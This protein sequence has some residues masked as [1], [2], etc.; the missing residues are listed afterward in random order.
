[1]SADESNTLLHVAEEKSQDD[2]EPKN[3]QI[4]QPASVKRRPSIEIGHWGRPPTVDSGAA[5]ISDEPQW[6][7]ANDHEQQSSYRNRKS[8]DFQGSSASIHAT[9][10]NEHSSESEPP[11]DNH[12]RIPHGSGGSPGAFAESATQHNNGWKDRSNVRRTSV[13]H[14][15][16]VKVEDRTTTG[17]FVKHVSLGLVH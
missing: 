6:Q 15:K 1:M 8:K 13:D 5:D 10:A 11:T 17:G 2:G 12:S 9:N 14:S 7:S 4:E 3:D 16:S